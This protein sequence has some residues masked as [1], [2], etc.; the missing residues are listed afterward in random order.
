MAK[1]KSKGLFRTL[2]RWGR[3][4][5]KRIDKA[6]EWVAKREQKE[7]RRATQEWTAEAH[8]NGERIPRPD[9][10]PVEWKS[11]LTD[12]D[13]E[14]WRATFMP[15]GYT[16]EVTLWP[17]KDDYEVRYLAEQEIQRLYGTYAETWRCVAI[18][19]VRPAVE[20]EDITGENEENESTKA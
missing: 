12:S 7:V 3:A 9:F 15:G 17:P 1:A 18:E 4:V 16:I 5:N 10:V 2:W 20:P 8:K 6:A 11:R 13:K 19:F 14:V